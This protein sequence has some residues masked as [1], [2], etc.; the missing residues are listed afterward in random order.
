[1]TVDEVTELTHLRAELA[2]LQEVLEFDGAWYL[3]QDRREMYEARVQVLAQMILH[4]EE[5]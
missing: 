4:L 5:A 1:M 3:P 2:A